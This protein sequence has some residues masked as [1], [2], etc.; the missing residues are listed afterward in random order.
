MLIALGGYIGN[1]VSKSVVR[2]QL[3]NCRSYQYNISTALELYAT[4][5]EGEYPR[6]LDQLAPKYLKV[7]PACPA[8]DKSYTYSTGNVGYNKEGKWDSYFLLTCPG[9]AH[10]SAGC[11]PNY[12]QYDAIHN[13]RT[14]RR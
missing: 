4:D 1:N 6:S 7:V 2:G 5:H 14:G 3:T 11:P 9:S 12:P 10:A 8:S 13:G